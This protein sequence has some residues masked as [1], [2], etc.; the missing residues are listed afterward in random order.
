MFRFETIEYLYLIGLIPVLIGLYTVFDANRKK[1]LSKLGNAEIIEKLTRNVSLKQRWI[2][3]V[4]TLVALMFLFFAMSNPQIG[5][6]M[7]EIKRE[8]IDVLIALDVSNSM[9]AE[10]IAPNRMAKAKYEIREFIKRLQGDRV[11]L[12]PFAGTAFTQCPLTLDYSTA[13]MFLDIIDQYTIPEQGTSIGSA[14]R[15]AIDSFPSKERKYKALVII[16]DGEDHESDILDVS[17]QAKEHGIVIYTIG[18][19]SLEGVPIP[20]YTDSGTKNGFKKDRAGNVVTTKLDVK[21]LQEI[22]RDTGGKFFHVSPDQG[23]LDVI[24]NE[25]SQMEKKELGSKE[26]TSYEDRFQIFLLIAI[27]F[28]FIEFFTDERKKLLSEWKGRFNL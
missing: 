2:K 1:K 8:G 13:N 22:A 28:L 25:I 6:K 4:F 26:Y 15:S 20:H 27:L 16:T 5:T 17:K 9:L 23:E 21:T 3:R 7:E 12:I 14:I 18:I 24:F 10:D 19:G 11:G